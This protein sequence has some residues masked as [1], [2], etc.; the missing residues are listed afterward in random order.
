MRVALLTLFSAFTVHS[1]ALADPERL[2]TLLHSD[3]MLPGYGG[4]IVQ[5]H[6]PPEAI[7][8]RAERGS[9]VELHRIPLA[10]GRNIESA[11]TPPE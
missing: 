1:M 7:A 3:L 10:V 2:P 8:A 6:V 5:P 11:P 4:L 9:A